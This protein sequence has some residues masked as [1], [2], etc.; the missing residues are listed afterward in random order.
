MPA[1]ESFWRSTFVA[2]CVGAQQTTEP[3]FIASLTSC[4]SR[5]VLPT[6]APPST[7]KGF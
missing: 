4:P 3:R 7:K 1:A 5:N 6:P 2:L